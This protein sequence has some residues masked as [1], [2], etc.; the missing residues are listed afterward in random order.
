[1]KAL[2]LYSGWVRAWHWLNAL[3]FLTL[4]LTG[5]SMHFSGSRWLIPFETARPLHNIA[6]VLLGFGWVWF[7]VA[8]WRSDNRR[9]YRIRLR[10]L[11]GRLWEQSRYYAVGIFRNDPH[12]F[13]PTESE[14]LNELQ[15]LTYIGVMYGLMPILFASG[16]AFLLV[17][18]LPATLLGI[19]S[20]WVVAMVHL[21]VAYLLALFLV[22]HLYVITTGDTVLANLKAMITGWH[23]EREP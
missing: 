11:L 15:K 19:G 23:V 8:N 14:K 3:L 9:H 10:G 2:Y 20:V 12:P 5:A 13:H 7:V 6:G 18:Y 1:M 21:T 17:P 22:T 16:F 4:M